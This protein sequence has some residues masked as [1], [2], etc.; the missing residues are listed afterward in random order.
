VVCD[1]VGSQNA[2]MTCMFIA[3]V[4]LALTLLSLAT[5]YLSAFTTLTT[6]TKLDCRMDGA[7]CNRCRLF[8]RYLET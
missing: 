6:I 2:N 4:I 3:R 5:L 1:L 8:V 7:A